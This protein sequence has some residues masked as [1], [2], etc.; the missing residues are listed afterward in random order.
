[1]YEPKFNLTHSIVNSLVKL[2]RER[3]IIQ[4]SG[5]TPRAVT[6]V[7]ND[8]KSVNLFHLAHIIGAN[9]TLKDAERLAEGKNLDVQDAKLIILNNFRNTLEFTRSSTANT[10]IDVDL[11]I[12]LHLNKI[13]VTT[14][15]ESWEAKFR[16]SGEEIDVNLDNWVDLR[17]KNIEAIRIQETLLSLIEWYKT[18]QGKIDPVIRIAIFIYRLMRISPFVAAN[19]LTLIAI[20]DLLLYKNGYIEETFLPITRNFDI[21]GDEY[22]ESWTSALAGN[23]DLTLWVERFVRNLSNDML[24]VK[25]KLQKLSTDEEKTTRRPFLDLNKR[26]LKIL[27]YLQNIPA[28]KREDYVHMMDVSTMTAF[29]DLDDLVK[30]KLLKIDGKGRGTKYMLK[31]R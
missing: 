2:E 27:R 28:V 12:L 17:D 8:S 10:Y 3:I 21:Y 1:M 22:I 20:A 31:N 4:K 15:K 7:K 13:M 29:R 11:N 25:E 14:W 18:Q 9:I 6:R 24:D 30:K 5:F 16:T 23:E 19:K 26:Q